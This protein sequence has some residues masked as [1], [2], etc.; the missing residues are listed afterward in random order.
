MR[1]TGTV[2]ASLC[3]LA[4]GAAL[5]AQANALA[6]VVC[7]VKVVSDK[8]KDVSS[9]EAWKKSWILPGMT[10]KDKA[11]AVWESVVAHQ[12]QD[13]PPSE[14]VNNEGTVQDAIKVFNVYGY[15]LCGVAANEIASLAR[16][17]GL[18]CR[19]STIVA[20]VVPEIEFEGGWHLFD[21][22]L[23]NFM[24]L[25][26]APADAV[27][28]KFS[29]ALTNYAVPNGKIASIEEI[30][31]AVRDWYAQN[32]DYLDRPQDAEA[33]PKGN[34]AKLRKFHG[35]GGWQGWRKGPKL[36]ADCPFYG[37]DG[38]LPAHT[39]G[40]YSTM[41]EYDGSTYFLYEAGYSMGYHVDIRLRP[42]EKLIRNWSNKGLFVNMDG[43]GEA[44]DA[45]QAT[46][47]RGN[48]TY[49]ARFGDIA[50]GR[51]GNGELIYKVP[52]DA[53]LEKSA[54]R[55]ENL[56]A[57]GKTLRAKDD[58]NPGI[59]EIR[60]PCSYVYLKGEMTL[61]ATVGEGGSVRVF[62]SD[63]N[64]LDWK[65]AGKV[66]KTGEETIDLTKRIIRRYDYRVRVL[67][68]G[69]GT[70]L[71]ALSFRHDVQHSQRPLPALARGANTITFSA[72]AQEGAIT[73]EGSC[74]PGVTKGRN[75][76][77]EDFH[78]EVNN[79]AEN[80]LMV[81]MAKGAGDIT[82]KVDTPGDLTRM[83]IL[84]H[85]RARDR[86]GGWDVQVSYDGGKQ[87]Q[88]VAQ[89]SGPTAAT[90]NFTE[91]QNVPA[92]VRTVYVRWSGKA[93]GNAAMLFNQRIDAYYKEAN[94]GFRP[95]KVTYL[96]EEGGIVR[97]DE[98]VARVPNETYVV[99]CAEN[100]TMKSIILEL[101]E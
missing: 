87:F 88:S 61:N 26:D 89:C 11:I 83:T 76:T 34:D 10:D 78:A 75:L 85:Y 84:T 30:R 91:V 60:N 94:A 90:G 50:P 36:L 66:E 9:L 6:G 23:I 27:N 79:L 101:A 62:F 80:G 86:R 47:G 73:V 43:T 72:G 56:V 54:W 96:W 35:E 58:A 95:V 71:S 93:G 38:W 3:V 17:S 22:S 97:K 39:H 98:H 4:L 44:P 41:Q 12:Y 42:G 32:P 81:D 49:C 1:L 74:N 100:P 52:L 25:K 40:W 2:L 77:Y 16:Y 67:L 46:I 18:N 24:V 21:A 37:G 68:G 57:D 69:R 64:G 45:L 5:F 31:A 59:L 8:V 13:S 53:S 19:V 33:K 65:E 14:F 7:N 82:Y 70:N 48:W 55:F 28:G 15:S 20:H 29:K 99:N 51:V 92:G 63:N